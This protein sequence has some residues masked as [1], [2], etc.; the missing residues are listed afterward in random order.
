ME[1][2][3]AHNYDKIFNPLFGELRKAESRFVINYGG[4]GSGKSY[5]Q[6]QHEIIKC[7]SS[8]QKLLVV[9]KYATSL[10]DSVV[11][12]FLDVLKKWELDGYYSENKTDR[13]IT[14]INGSQILFKGLDDPEKIKSISGITRVWIEEANE[15]SLPEFNQ[16]NLRLRGADD[17][18]ITLTFNPIDEEH[19]IKKHF[20]DNTKIANFTSVIRTTYK[21]NKFIDS[22]YIEQ[23]EAYKEI[24]ENYYKIYALGEWGGIQEGRIFKIWETIPE[25]PHTDKAWYGLDFGFSIDPTA[26]VRVHLDGDNLYVDEVCYQK[27]LVTSDVA[28]IMKQ[29]GYTSEV[30]VCDSAEP[31]SIQ[32]LQY[33]GIH[34]ISA[35][36]R[37][38]SINA[39][40]D[41][42]KRHKVYVTARSHNIIKENMFY[43][44]RTDK[45]GAFIN[46]PKDVFNHAI[47]AIRYAVS[48]YLF[49]QQKDQSIF[50]D[51]EQI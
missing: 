20:F 41:F 22:A 15:L 25:F 51:Y 10:R 49:A 29:E 31:K 2:N 1:F 17:L 35:D 8:R 36:K 30:V 24:D 40:I 47:D 18:Q 14:F 9:R 50:I 4:S 28:N 23:L 32:D 6:T 21:D 42:L 46:Q 39:G 13:T 26:I 16:L 11:A 5:S 45:N 27:G 12:L 38:G 43:Q 3:F 48:L 33:Y 44:W 19:W 37:P 7:F 34:A